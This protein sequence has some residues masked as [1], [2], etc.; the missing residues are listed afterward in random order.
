MAR[1]LRVCG[2]FGILL[3]IFQVVEAG[4]ASPIWPLP[5]N[6]YL[7]SAFGKYR[8]THWHGGMDV[9]THRQQ[10]PCVAVDDGWVERIAVTPGGYGRTVYLRLSDERTAVYAHLSRFA[11]K[12]ESLLREKELETGTYRIDFA[13]DSLAMVFHRGDTI[14]WTGS[15]GFGPPH[16]HFELRRGAKQEDPFLEYQQTD[17]QRP[18]VDG[19][20]LVEATDENAARFARG[21][22]IHLIKGK[23][24]LTGSCRIPEKTPF[25]LLLKARDPLPYGQHRT[26]TQCVLWQ[27]ETKD[28]L[29]DMRRESIDLVSQT[30]M[31]ASTDYMGWRDARSEWWRLHAGKP[32]D[33]VPF[34]ALRSTSE[35]LILDVYDAAGNRNRIRLQLHAVQNNASGG[36]KPK[37]DEVGVSKQGLHGFELALHPEEKTPLLNLASTDSKNEIAILP[38]IGFYYW[39]TLSYRPTKGDVD[40]RTYLYERTGKTV[41]FLSAEHDSTGRL[42]ASISHSGVFGVATDRTPPTLSVRVVAGKLLFKA[43]DGQTG[44]D[45][46]TVRCRVDGRTAIA[47]YEMEESGGTIWTPFTLETGSHDIV[48]EAQDKVGN[49]ARLEKK[50]VVGKAGKRKR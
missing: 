29:M 49:E 17:T 22:D 18:V 38:D 27:E 3:L 34:P 41:R 4:A 28:T 24:T 39:A 8:R 48:L 47:E 45:S 10:L 37:Q 6:Q 44:I 25:A 31:W 1:T 9:G 36:A 21:T 42:R 15:T 35:I 46:R 2:L 11:P 40:H 26:W 7:S 23:E 5:D 13:V 14:A 32:G 33:F 20:R 16:L 50:I 30:T 43:R 12:L 19:L